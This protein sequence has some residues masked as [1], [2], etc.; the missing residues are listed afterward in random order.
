M[1]CKVTKGTKDKVGG[2]ALLVFAFMLYFGFP[3]GL[4]LLCAYLDSVARVAV[5]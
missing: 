5:R 4:G 2:F 3:V 1:V